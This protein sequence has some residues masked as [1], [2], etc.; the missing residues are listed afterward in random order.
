MLYTKDGVPLTVSGDSVFNPDGENFGY[1]QGDHVYGLGG[2]YRGT[3]VN[4]RL[5]YRSTDSARQG[6]ARAASAGAASAQAHSAGTADWG[7]EPN[8]R[9]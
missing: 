3:I 8:L 7:D 6:S 2:E 4:G 9:P 1:V 5:I